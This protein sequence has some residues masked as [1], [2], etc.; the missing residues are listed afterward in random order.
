MCIAF[1]QMSA[2]DT[3]ELLKFLTAN[4][5]PFHVQQ[6]PRGE[7]VRTRIENSYY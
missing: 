4:R 1:V 3:D 7:D 5:F 2:S 6:A